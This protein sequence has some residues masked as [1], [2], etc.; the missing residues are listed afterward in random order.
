[1]QG[2]ERTKRLEKYK[3]WRWYLDLADGCLTDGDAAMWW[4]PALMMEM[5]MYWLRS[6]RTLKEWATEV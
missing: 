6:R 4:K 3:S 5:A 2:R 1:M